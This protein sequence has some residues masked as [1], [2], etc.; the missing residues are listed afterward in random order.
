[1]LRIRFLAALLFGFV[2]VC[3]AQ[4]SVQKR[5]LNPFTQSITIDSK[6]CYLVELQSAKTKEL[7]VEAEFEGEYQSDLAVTI[8]EDGSNIV[9]A[10]GFS[11]NFL[12]P[13]DKLSAHKVISIAMKITLPEGMVV[14]LHGTNSN[15]EASGRYHNLEVTLADGDCTLETV[16]EQVRVKTQTGMIAVNTSS[17]EI[18]AESVYGKL[19]LQNIPKGN[20]IYELKSV[21]G[22]IYVYR[23][24]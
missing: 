3:H 20:T 24:E 17:G 1:M 9:I 23:T 4:K 7:R 14:R 8:Q 22:N 12:H 10:T 2:A 11:P 13:N 16:S 19:V 6:N 21:E 5:I 18:D 15:V